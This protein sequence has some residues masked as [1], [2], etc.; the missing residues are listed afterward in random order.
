[1][2]KQPTP[3][4]K[5]F[6][7]NTIKASIWANQTERSGNTAVRHSVRFQKRFRDANGNWRD[8]DY[9][10]PEDLPSIELVAA[11]AFEFCV[12]E[13]RDVEAEDPA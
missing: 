11:K 8:T 9:Y 6:R 5:E 12:L 4:T 2:D 1:M 3:P 13:E 10:F 7:V